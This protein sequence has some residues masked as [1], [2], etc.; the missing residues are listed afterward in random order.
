V[1][2]IVEGRS[3]SPETIEIFRDA[4]SGNGVPEQVEVPHPPSADALVLSDKPTT[5]G[6]VEMTTGCGRRCKFCLPDLNPQIAIPKDRIMASVATNVEHGF[7]Q[8]SLATEDMFIWGQVGGKTPFF[9]PNRE[10]LLDLYSSVAN[11][12]GVKK[13]VLSHCTM[14]PAL[15]DP[16]LIRGLSEV[17]LDKSPLHIP[18]FGTHPDKKMLAP[19]IGLETGSVRMAKEVM[20]AKAVPFRIED[21]PSVVIRSLE[22]YN[23]N[24]W[25]PVLTIMV[26]SPGETDEDVKATLDLIFEM[27]RRG[28]FGFLVP[29]I[30][31]PLEGTRMEQKRGVGLTQNL[32]P[33]QWQLMMKCWK[34]NVRPASSAW[35]TPLA[36]R[37]GGLLLWA[38]RLRK[39]N[40]P[41][42]FWPMMSFSRVAP[43]SWLYRT[44]KLYEG[45][46]LDIKT[47]E[48]LLET[49]RPNH[50]KFLR[51]DPALPPAEIAVQGAA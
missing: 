37:F 32:S 46:P 49:I 51:H 5:F 31:T 14:A 9:F 33:L 47:R 50:R 6:V 26:G 17:L 19:L 13:V 15:V 21:W 11:Y 3:E 27:E 8:V 1:D 44:G 2:C 20:P 35:W 29:S 18:V 16:E 45:K 28:L 4:V 22:V 48:D 34:M 30:F 40:G 25:F 7:D 24:N 42:F 41:N 43:D 36:Y 23:Q 12:P 38:T 39:T 10:A